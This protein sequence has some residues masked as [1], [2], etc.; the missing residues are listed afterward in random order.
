MITCSLGDDG[1][2][3]YE[4]TC[5]FT[6]NTGYE[7]TDS[8]TR[9]CLNDGS[10]SGSDDVCRK[11]HC[12]SLTSPNGTYRCNLGSD[13]VT[14]YEDI[15]RLVCITGYEVTGSDTRTC[16]SNGSWSGNDDVCR[17]VP[18]LSLTDPNNGMITCLLGDDGVPF[19][20]DTCSFTCNTG[21]EVTGSDTR[22]C[23]SN[24]SWS[25]NDDVCRRVPCLSLT[26]PNNGMI[27]CLLGDDGVPSYEDTCSFTCNTGYELT[28]SDTRT[29][30]SDGSWSGS[31]DV[32]RRVPCLSLTDPNNGMITCLLGDDG[33]PSYEDTCSFTCNTGY[34]LTG[35]DTRT[36]QSD[37]SWSGNETICRKV[38]CPLLT[39]PNNGHINCIVGDDGVISYKDNCSV[40]CNTGYELTG[41]DTRTC[42][43]NGNWSGSDDVCRKVPCSSL[44][45]PNNGMITCSLGDDGVPSYEDTCSFTC[46]TGYELTGSDTRTC[47]SDGSWSG[48]D[49]VCRRVS[50]PSLTGPNN[51]MIN[52]SL[53]DDGVPSYEDTCSFTCNTGYELTGS[54]TRTCQSDGSWSGNETICRKVHCPLLTQPNNGHINCIVGDDGV[55]SYK[56]NCSVSCNTG[57][58]LTGSDTRTCQSNGNWSGSDDVC[59]KV[60]CSSLTDPNNGMITCSLGD[61]G[62]PSY[63][64]TCSFTCNTGYELTG[65]DTRTC[66]SNGNWSGSDDV[67]RKV[68][69]SSLT[70]PNNGMI[71]CSLGDDGVPSYEDTCSFTCNTGYELTGSDTRTC[72]SDGSWSGSDDVCRKAS[73]GGSSGS[74]GG[75]VIIGV[76][77]GAAVLII[78]IVV[79][80][81]IVLFCKRKSQLKRAYPVTSSRV[82][83]QDTKDTKNSQGTY[84]HIS[85]TASIHN[86]IY[87]ESSF[88]TTPPAKPDYEGL[89]SLKYAVVDTALSSMNGT[90]E[91]Q[92]QL[93]TSI[94][95]TPNSPP[96]AMIIT[97]ETEKQIYDEPFEINE[98]YGPIYHEPPSNVN[99]IYEQFE[100]KK[101]H[102]INHHEVR[103]LEK[104]GAG[105]FGVVT[106]AM[107][108]S[109]PDE[110]IEVALKTLNSDVNENERVRFLQE[111]AIMCQ[112]DHEN[113]IKLYGVVTE[114]PVMIVL[115]Y[116][117]RGDLSNLLIELRPSDEVI[118]HAKL[119]IVLLKFCKEIAAGMTYLNGKKFVH[120]DLAARNILVSEKCT[121]KIADFGM[122]RDLLDENYY[123]TK[124]GKIPVKWTAP[125]ALHYR[126]YSVQSDVWSYGSV[127][128]EI[129][130]LG[131][132]PFDDVSNLESLQKVDSGYRLPPPPG[133]PRT[134]YRMMIKCWHPDPRSRP[135]F[136]QITKLLAGNGNYLLGWSDEDKKATGQDG[137]KLGAPLGYA[138]NLYPDL[139]S[140]YKQQ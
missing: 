130:A 127:L 54:D 124:G 4:D 135:Q 36:C 87:E 20:E 66:Q 133:C 59:R 97:L 44:T 52:C 22:T 5:S 131:Y 15:C 121:C 85:A 13:G 100:G 132:K 29:C 61:D 113:V 49:D 116:M 68:P 57:Y 64:D 56:D 129:W 86:A 12:P 25:G 107:W 105:E 48:S 18:C 83:S 55:I 34:E 7:L 40:S 111:A 81:L 51:G 84:F 19:Y 69:C 95:E 128:Y 70:D 41:S 71:T 76:A 28:G 140:A 47:Q 123:I 65:S 134:F 122:S 139:Q 98:D 102:K 67:C 72:Q 110:E 45:D 136:G 90:Y 109:S 39:Q 42:Q 125:E 92:I 17:R 103:S 3:S 38:H 8:D 126:K 26:D 94:Y 93:P 106:H 75:G 119:P 50:C 77:V 73:T 62:V 1:V 74:L 112:F 91:N 37:G 16:Q 2:P 60:P 82:S 43:S 27:T 35:S 23:Q 58:E 104:L 11:V 21:Y 108:I 78:V 96:N 24:G 46:N 63:E 137:M 114:A 80:I 6:C 117:S 138:K 99:K 9:T 115:E 101:I 53:G 30:Q 118:T 14:S 31:N 79:I 120:R 10:W 88:A 33:V 89:D 32:C